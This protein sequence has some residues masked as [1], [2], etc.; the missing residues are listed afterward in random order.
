MDRRLKF[1]VMMVGFLSLGLVPTIICILFPPQLAIIENK[2]TDGINVSLNN[3]YKTRD[4]PSVDLPS[5]LVEKIEK[6]ITVKNNWP[7]SIV[8]EQNPESQT[9]NIL[10]GKVSKVINTV[11]FYE[12]GGVHKQTNF[13][14][15]D[16]K[17]ISIEKLNAGNYF[18]LLE[19][20]GTVYVK[21]I[22]IG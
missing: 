21:K 15:G 3:W 12:P 6:Q 17:N 22:L 19:I 13:N 7:E 1:L 14:A 9:I 16:H 11:Q 8:I 20:N 4:Y 18:I 5:R 10:T 2:N